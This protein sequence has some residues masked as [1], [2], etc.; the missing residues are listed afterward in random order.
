MAKRQGPPTPIKNMNRGRELHELLSTG[1]ELIVVCHNNPDPD[2]LASA[3][4]LGKIAGNAGIDERRVMYSGTISHQQNRAFVNLLEMNLTEFDEQVIRNR[5]ENSLVAFV[6]HAIPGQNNEVS[7]DI[8]IDI[9]IDHHPA[10]DIEATFIDHREQIGATSTIL[11]QYLIELEIVPSEKLA[12]GLLFA[13]RRETLGFL[14][15]VTK[16]E[17]QAAAA[18]H[19]T[20]DEE[21][22]RRLT[23]PAVSSA[24]IDA[25]ALAITNRQV[26]NSVLIT[27]VGRTS[28]RDSLPQAADYLATLEGVG[29]AIV[30][31]IVKEN[32]EISARSTDSRVHLGD[33]LRD[34][35]DGVGSAGGHRSFAGGEV[36]LGIVADYADDDD[37]LADIVETVITNRLV[38]ALNLSEAADET[39]EQKTNS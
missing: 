21:L 5:G 20:I 10:E 9:V 12:T 1:E 7:D 26:R 19:D 37:N 24:T 34:A 2:C 39:D 31:G 13:I 23:M 35:F 36:P 22:L 18:L 25:I 16:E 4:A 33:A 17:Y 14:R 38:K 32:I 8:M 29:T 15:D 3:L 6:D 11:S 30:F 28:E 27:H